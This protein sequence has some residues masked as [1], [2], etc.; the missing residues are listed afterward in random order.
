MSRASL[1]QISDP[2]WEQPH[3]SIE[4]RLL[5]GDKVAAVAAYWWVLW[6]R[7]L[8]AMGFAVLLL[9]AT[10]PDIA[11]IVE[12]FAA[13]LLVDGGLALGLALAAARHRQHWKPLCCEGGFNCAAAVM[14]LTIPALTPILVV[15]TTAAW[16]I[17]SGV[18]LLLA[19][20]VYGMGVWLM[21]L[22]AG[23]SIL[24]GLFF[25]MVPVGGTLVITIW[26]GIYALVFGASL[27]GLSWNMRRIAAG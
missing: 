5:G 22:A 1:S 26:L 4:M 13:Y 18:A 14:M 6:L 7:G 12:L 9:W 23:S 17:G 25:I 3:M 27:L 11:S 8:S 16:A 10:R 15:Y 19:S 2:R 20:A 21:A 24:L